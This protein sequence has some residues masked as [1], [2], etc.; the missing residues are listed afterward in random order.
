[1]KSPASRRVFLAW[2]MTPFGRFAPVTTSFSSNLG[3]SFTPQSRRWSSQTL[4]F[5]CRPED[6]IHH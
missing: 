1:M 5:R 4:D 6:D 3:G 2:R